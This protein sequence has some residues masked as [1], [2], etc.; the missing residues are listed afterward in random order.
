MLKILVRF[1]E[2]I[3]TGQMWSF[4]RDLSADEEPKNI[5]K[6]VFLSLLAK[7]NHWFVQTFKTNSFLRWDYAWAISIQKV[8]LTENRNWKWKYILNFKIIIRI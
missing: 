6:N 1:W 7:Q 3:N 2:V 8:W 5:L 4:K